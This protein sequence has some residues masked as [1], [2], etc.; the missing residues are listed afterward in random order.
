MN[1]GVIRWLLAELAGTKYDTATMFA[2]KQPNNEQDQELG[3][4]KYEEDGNSVQNWFIGSIIDTNLLDLD[5]IC[6]WKILSYL[7]GLKNKCFD[8]RQKG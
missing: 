7:S 1:E 3:E 5:E 8:Y 6:F 4:T 2:A